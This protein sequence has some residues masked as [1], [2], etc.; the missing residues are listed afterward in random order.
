VSIG[1]PLT[2]QIASCEETA[3]EVM[4]GALALTI[5]GV[6][7]N[8]FT[9]TATITNLAF[10][11]PGDGRSVTLDGGVTVSYSE[12]ADPSLYR[13]ILRLTVRD[14]LSIHVNAPF[15]ETVTLLGDY[16]LETTTDWR[17]FDATV[18]TTARG[19]I[20]SEAAGGRVQ[21]STEQPIVQAS[22][23]PHPQQGRVRLLGKT[24]SVMTLEALPTNQIRI[25]A[26]YDGDGTVDHSRDQDWSWLF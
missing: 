21:L 13:E 16:V 18:T 22:M 19:G 15:D 8:G 9:G 25:E 2:I 6:T 11:T 23:Q 5:T 3:G 17:G 14:P 12:H 7:D 20:A 26:D 10:S 1:E 4:N 24:G